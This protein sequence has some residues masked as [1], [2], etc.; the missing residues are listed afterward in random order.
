M[1]EGRQLDH[2]E[3]G[4]QSWINPANYH[5]AEVGAD[6]EWNGKAWED[7]PGTD[8]DNKKLNF[9]LFR[10]G[11]YE[12]TENPREAAR[13]SVS[14]HFRSSVSA[15]AVAIIAVSSLTASAFASAPQKRDFRVLQPSTKVAM[16]RVA[17]REIS[18]FPR[19]ENAVMK[20]TSQFAQGAAGERLNLP[21][22]LGIIE[23][24]LFPTAK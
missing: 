19:S 1:T 4:G 17:F 9:V 6:G 5:A 14:H 8:S 2:L 24:T 11:L 23:N 12:W 18:A 10:R 13:S 20:K 16:E 21:N 3:M 15:L 7:M 22:G